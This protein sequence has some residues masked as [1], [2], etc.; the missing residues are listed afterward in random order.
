MRFWRN[1]SRADLITEHLIE[2]M[3]DRNSRFKTRLFKDI[4]ANDLLSASFNCLE[5]AEKD[6]EIAT[7]IKHEL[8]CRLKKNSETCR[9]QL[10]EL[11][12]LFKEK[13]VKP[14]EWLQRARRQIRLLQNPPSRTYN[15]SH[16]I[17]VILMDYFE[18]DN[19]YGVYVG[20]TFLLPEERLK[21][22]KSGTQHSPAVKS[23]G[24]QLL[25][26]LMPYAPKKVTDR[27][28]LLFES[29]VHHCLAKTRRSLIR[30]PKL[31]R[32]VGNGHNKKPEDWPNG[33][34]RRLR[35]DLITED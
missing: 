25:R 16:S 14:I 27:Q 3:L 9:S 19:N 35:A 11:R 10:N 29:A 18:E 17:Y 6:I 22:H 30:E 21:N 31:L 28:S 26:S 1:G 7:L 20:E 13:K 12:T 33:F 5:G 24:I 8:E 4:Q 32:V 2:L 23:R 15:S 34:Q